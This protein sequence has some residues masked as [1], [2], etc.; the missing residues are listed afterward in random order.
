VSAQST[1]CKLEPLLFLKI[2]ND[3][4]IF[5]KEKRSRKQNSSLDDGPSIPICRRKAACHAVQPQEHGAVR[6]PFC[7]LLLQP[8]NRNARAPLLEPAST[9][10]QQQAEHQILLLVPCVRLTVTYV[11]SSHA[12]LLQQLRH[13]TTHLSREIALARPARC[14]IA[15]LREPTNKR[16]L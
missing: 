9:Y 4:I 7:F 8:Q 13:S 1:T 5:S 10:Q 2:L 6:S 14:L 15:R 3:A 11:P 12:S 16:R